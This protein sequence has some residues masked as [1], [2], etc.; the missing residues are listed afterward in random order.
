MKPEDSREARDPDG[1]RSIGATGDVTST[2]SRSGPAAADADP[3]FVEPAARPT[4]VRRAL[5]GLHRAW[6]RLSVTGLVVGL[7]FYCFSLTPSLIPRTWLYQGVVMGICVVLGYGIGVFLEWLILKVGFHPHWNVRVSRLAWWVLAGLTVVLMVLFLVLG[8]R[9]QNEIRV[10]FG[11]DTLVAGNGLLILV[12]ALVVALLLLQISRGL[13]RVV[14]WLTGWVDR[15][16]PKPIARLVSVVAVTALV[17]LLFTGVIWDG[18]LHLLNNVYGAANAAVDPTLQQPTQAERSG[19]PDSLESWESLGAAGRTFVSEGPTLEELRAFAAAGTV[20]DPAKVREPMRVYG[21]LN[22]DGDLDAT[23]A[24]VVAELDRTNAWDRSLLVVATT[25]GTGWIDPGMSDSLELM[26][27]GDTAIATM[28]YSYLPSW[29]SFIGDRETP[30]AAGKALFDAVFQR[31]SQLPKNA[32]PKLIAAGISL[33]SFGA[34]GAFSGVQDLAQRT[35]GALFVGTPSFTPL[36]AELTKQRDRGSLQRAPVLDGGKQ[37]RWGEQI[38]N[39]INLWRLGTNWDASRVVYVQHAS[40]GAV[41]WSPSLLWSKPDWLREPNGPDVLSN[42][43]WYP[44]VTF[45]QLTADLFVAGG[46]DIPQGHGHQ[47]R[48]EY[49]DAF[50]ALWAPD[51]WSACDTARLKTTVSDSL[52][53]PP[54]GS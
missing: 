35:D 34:Q 24:N 4:P 18:A 17:V 14:Q 11:M 16:I 26:H 29:I 32:R 52:A 10:L 44:V 31:W 30:P 42:V 5:I 53:A 21:G 23:A 3:T 13:R 37:V 49:A 48:P 15:V 47:Y 20:I 39:G 2:S 43:N 38:P 41:W 33:G 1:A 28:Q 8:V 40:D 50:A 9:W 46:S 27:G 36:E 45:W 19:S 22:P 7:I 12:I 6:S 54:A 51:N 25:T